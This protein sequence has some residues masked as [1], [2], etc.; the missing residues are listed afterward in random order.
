MAGRIEERVRALRIARKLSQVELAHRVRI[1][2]Q[3][4]GAVESGLYQPGVAVAIRL[5]QELGEAV[6]NLFGD[7][8]DSRP[9]IAECAA[10][11]ARAPHTRVA[12][13]RLGGRL[14]RWQCPRARWRCI[15]R[16][17]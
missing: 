10:A 11:G 12:L 8:D 16:E 2:R 15:R 17:V 1:L 3:A 4:L 13:A 9:L 6:E 7:H 14:W 5:A